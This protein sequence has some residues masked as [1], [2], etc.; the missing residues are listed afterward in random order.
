MLNFFNA[1]VI[2]FVQGVAEFLPISSS[3]HLVLV[4]QLFNI[5]GDTLVLTIF[6]HVTTLCSILYV[7]RKDILNLIKHP[8]CKTNKLLVVATIPTVILALVLKT[9]IEG[10]FNLNFILFGFIITAL[11]LGI[12]DYLSEKRALLSKTTLASANN[13]NLSA[14]NAP[15]I[16]TKDNTIIHSNPMLKVSGDITNIDINY[17][18][19]I[20]IG[21]AQGLAC[22]PGIS[23]SGS[24]IATGLM[25]KC[26]KSEVTTF[27]F[28]LSIPTIVGSLILALVKVNGAGLYIGTGSLIVACLVSFFVG[29]LSIGLLMKVVKKQK[30]S[31]FSYYLLALVFVILFIKFV[32]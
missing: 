27:S 8:L 10:S 29:I 28:L 18:Q 6:L 2:G 17:W 32:F 9:F 22:F 5:T 20:V 31:Y 21:L 4:Y 25:L 7:Y 19:A 14:L 30:L 15:K 24:T 11:L 1:I 3:G 12:A 26:D 23:R 13:S 16:T